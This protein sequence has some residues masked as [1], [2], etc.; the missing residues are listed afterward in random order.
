MKLQVIFATSLIIGL[1]AISRGAEDRGLS[2]FLK[3]RC[4]GCHSGREAEGQFRVD[5]LREVNRESGAAWLKVLEKVSLREM[6][7]PEELQPSADEVRQIVE[8]LSREIARLDR[9]ALRDGR[10]ALLTTL[11]R[12]DRPSD[13]NRVAHDL[14][15]G[16]VSASKYHASPRVW[17]LSPEIYEGL[18]GDLGAKNAPGINPPFSVAPGDGFKDYASEGVVDESTTAQLIRNAKAIVSYW[19]RHKFEDGKLKAENNAIR[20]AVELLDPQQPPTRKQIEAAI[21][22][23][24]KRALRRAPTADELDRYADLHRRAAAASGQF[25]AAKTML[26]A[27]LLRPDVTFRF[28][29]GV[30]EPDAE[31]RVRLAP[32][33]IA[34][35]LAFALT[36]RGPDGTLI[37]AAEKGELANREEVAAQTRRMLDDPK[38]EKPRILRFFR[39]YFGYADAPSVFKDNKDNPDH[40]AGM[41]VN[42]TDQLVLWVLAQDRDVFRTLLTT[43]KSF[44]NYRA[45]QKTGQNARIF[46]DHAQMRSHTSYG[47]PRDWKWT[48]EQPI[49]LPDAERCGILTQPSWLVAQSMNF[50][51]HVIRRGKWIRERLLGGH[52]PDLPI[53]IDAVVSDDR[54]QTLRSRLEKTREEYCWKCHRRMDDLGLA[55]E[56]FDHFG[57]FRTTECDQPVNSRG[58]IERSG[59]PKLDGD[60]ADAIVLIRRLA[61]SPRVQQVFIRHVFRYWLGR[62]E[63]PG[64]APT[65]VA[66]NEAYETSGGS[67]KELLIALLTSES[68]LYR[69]PSK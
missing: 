39:Q 35:A 51:N 29:M 47:L 15:F 36:D 69:V 44:V 41:L 37:S 67:F 11:P 34:N 53:T 28:E 40:H 60:V 50:D 5:E 68:F 16:S 52:I 26:T 17:L 43:R 31:G 23:S 6:P 46:N 2:N 10:P 25:E 18:V 57:R 61:D 62:N 21:H 7:P 8:T 55:F 66:M 20:Q 14:L 12:L 24:F 63:T 45:S 9:D 1:A 59:D 4:V 58:A 65:L 30:G 19:L 32:L 49:D 48:A 64:D 22:E 13:G 3:Q 33:E 54:S 56:M 38:R 42:D 27:V